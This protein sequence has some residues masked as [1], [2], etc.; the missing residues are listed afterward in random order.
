MGNSISL[1]MIV[2][3]EEE[4]LRCCLDSAAGGVDEIIV[5]DTGSGDATVPIAES[6]GARVI[7]FPWQDDFAVARNRSLAEATGD[8]ILVLDAD[9]ELPPNTHSMLRGLTLRDDTKAWN[10]TVE[11]PVTPGAN[12]AVISHPAL[13]MFRN[14]SEHR[15]DGIVHEQ[16]QPAILKQC[17]TAAIRYANIGISHRS[18][19]VNTKVARNIRLLQIALAAQ[20]FDP[21]YNFTLG[22]SYLATGELKMGRHHFELAHLASDKG[23]DYL[24]ALYRHYTLCLYE[25]GELTECLRVLDEGLGYFPAYPD[26]HFLKGRLFFALGLLAQAKACFQTCTGFQ[27]IGPEYTIMKGVSTYLSQVKLA[28]VA[29]KADDY[30]LAAEHL[31]NAYNIIKS[32][33][34]L[35]RLARTLK[36]TL[37]ITELVRFLSSRLDM[38]ASELASLLFDLGE[39]GACLEQCALCSDQ[40]ASSLLR[41]KCLTRTRQPEVALNILKELPDTVQTAR[42]TWLAQWLAYGILNPGDQGS[43]A[44]LVNEVAYAA[45]IEGNREESLSLA[46]AL[47]GEGAGERLAQFVLAAGQ[48]EVAWAILE[49]DT[50]EGSSFLRGKICADL[51]RHREAFSYFVQATGAGKEKTTHLRVLEQALTQCQLMVLKL[52]TVQGQDGALQMELFRLASWQLKLGRFKGESTGA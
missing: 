6:Y 36:K 25:M 48:P 40:G 11:T 23:S 35:V 52:L 28:Q 50:E 47:T 8:W 49:Q 42:E 15:Y 16:I 20:P 24:P 9:E 5:V 22:V 14:R 45:W 46:G 13:R 30:P 19:Q 51:G 10:F 33:K 7:H 38:E 1:C 12:A 44:E 37:T 3:D 21:F 39:Y 26:L 29:E 27:R 32:Y 18:L 41:A 31:A 34:I 2:R 4:H 43:T 17:P